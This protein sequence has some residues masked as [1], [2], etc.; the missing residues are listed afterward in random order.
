MVSSAEGTRAAQSASSGIEVVTFL[1]ILWSNRKWLALSVLGAMFLAG[2]ASYLVDKTFQARS[3]ILVEIPKRRERSLIF[4]DPLSVLAYNSWLNSDETFVR[5]LNTVKR[6]RDLVLQIQEKGH[7]PEQIAGMSKE[8]IRQLV[9]CSEDEAMLLAMLHLSDIQGLLQYKARDF[10]KLEF[11]AFKRN[12]RSY[13]AIEKETGIEVTYSPIIDLDARSETP[14]KAAL[15]SNLWAITFVE[16]A[17]KSLTE[18]TTN[19]VDDILKMS[20]ST[21]VLLEESVNRLQQYQ[22]EVGIER[23]RQE[24]QTKNLNLFG[25]TIQTFVETDPEKKTKTQTQQIQTEGFSEALIPKLANVEKTIR[26]TEGQIGLLD[27]YL[28][29]LEIQGSWIG[30]TAISPDQARSLLQEQI[31][32]ALKEMNRLE[33]DLEQKEQ[34][35]SLND[36]REMIQERQQALNQ[37]REILRALRNHP[38]R[39]Q[40]EILERIHQVENNIQAQLRELNHLEEQLH[41]FELTRQRMDGYRTRLSTLQARLNYLET[42]QRYQGPGVESLTFTLAK[43]DMDLLDEQLR[44]LQSELL[45]VESQISRALGSE[46]QQVEV[47][48]ARKEFYQTQIEQVRQQRRNLQ[49]SLTEDIQ[50][51]LLL[52]KQVEEASASFNFLRREYM[53]HKTKRG[54]LLTLLQENQSAYRSLQEQIRNLQTEIDDLTQKISAA[55]ATLNRLEKERDSYE[56]AIVQFSSQVSE[57]VVERGR[58]VADARVQARA[59]P[60]DQRVAPNRYLWVITAGLMVLIFDLLFLLFRRLLEMAPTELSS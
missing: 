33:S 32:E 44:T 35:G 20:E 37:E 48:K 30:D 53:R 52:A 39:N 45:Q 31:A 50:N 15:L 3:K 10:E 26:S 47:L 57:A 2:V 13:T 56:D 23:L 21:Q 17:R 41:E 6:L 34:E 36:L 18:R 59:Y 38:D 22:G 40:P 54:E 8:N 7:T 27:A 60:P 25:L 9:N 11:E 49:S 24:L 12:F 46:S 4:G 19:I 1:R 43:R 16:H 29:P 5:V 55:E 51:N 28:T 58:L 42:S 14:E